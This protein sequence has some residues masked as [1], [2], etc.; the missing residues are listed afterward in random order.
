M[1]QQAVTPRF[2]IG[3][4][5]S[6]VLGLLV[7]TGPLALV[8]GLRSLRAINGSD[9]RLRGRPLAIAGMALGLLGT[10]FLLFSCLA[11]GLMHV[12]EKSRR[13]HCADNLRRLGLAV[14]LFYDKHAER[15]PPGTV[16]NR[17]LAPAQRFSW[18][19]AV[20]PY[21]DQ[22]SP[23]AKQWVALYD[24]IDFQKPWDAPANAPAVH[25]TIP[26]FVCPAYP[27]P[28]ARQ[29]PGLTT[30]V[31]LAGIGPDAPLLPKNNPWAGF[32]GYN[33]AISRD[34]IRR[35][36]SYTMMATETEQDNGPW[37]GGGPS[38]V[39]GL[40]PDGT[41]YGG[42]GRPF[43]GLHA[44]VFNVLWVDGSVRPVPDTIAPTVFRAQATLGE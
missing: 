32:F 36:T 24:K 28:E 9:G 39:R 35:G 41:I 29:N 10:F 16:G 15:F 40:D 14:N 34:D 31:G 12:H 33:R 17:E 13:A 38:T 2:S 25:Q 5:V 30:Y 1:S 19:A 11:V 42:P 27:L 3:A 6:L 37:A 26:R 20:L 44:G 7:I 23:A 4:L 8:A 21:L 22:G 43:G 18:L